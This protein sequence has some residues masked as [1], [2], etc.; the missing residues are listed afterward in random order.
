VTSAEVI[1]GKTGEQSVSCII[2]DSFRAQQLRPLKGA[3]Y[4]FGRRAT[5]LLIY[6]ST[7]DAYTR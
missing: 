3:S 6:S 4:I 1:I 5:L 2:G 7:N